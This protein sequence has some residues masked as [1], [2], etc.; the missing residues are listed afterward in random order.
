M[1]DFILLKVESTEEAICLDTGQF[2]KIGVEYLII[3][4]KE[5]Y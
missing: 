1:V 2:L 5:E 4:A 3:K